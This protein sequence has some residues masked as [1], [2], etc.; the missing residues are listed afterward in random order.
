MTEVLQVVLQTVDNVM[1]QIRAAEIIRQGMDL[2]R[3]RTQVDVP[4]P[5]SG[6]MPREVRSGPARDR[7]QAARP[8][9]AHPSGAGIISATV[10]LFKHP[11]QIG[12]WFPTLQAS[13]WKGREEALK[14]KQSF[15]KLR[16]AGVEMRQ[17]ED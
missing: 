2:S 17:L 12:A 4:D 5:P 7:G 15:E 10:Y 3:G 13:W 9:A 14:A 1:W 8:R 11:D 16:D 6:R